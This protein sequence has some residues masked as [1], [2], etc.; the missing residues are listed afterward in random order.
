[1]PVNDSHRRRETILTLEAIW[2]RRG[3]VGE[4][5]IN[6]WNSASAAYCPS[7]GN[8]PRRYQ[9]GAVAMAGT[10]RL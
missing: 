7:T 3:H 1:M 2:R 10:L 9:T 6:S 8:R 4:R 5:R